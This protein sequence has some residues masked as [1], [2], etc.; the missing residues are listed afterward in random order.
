MMMCRMIDS[1]CLHHQKE[2]VLIL[3]EKIKG[4]C[5]HFGK[6]RF[7]AVFTVNLVEH[8]FL[9]IEPQ[10][11]LSISLL[12]PVACLNDEIP[13][14]P[15]LGHKVPSIFPLPFFCLRKEENLPS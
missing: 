4:F 13:I 15:G 1:S 10:D 6:A 3:T 14:L 7:I 12:H 2:S 5:R 11:L 8:I 9:I